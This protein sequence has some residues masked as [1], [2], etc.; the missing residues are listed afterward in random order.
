MDHERATGEPT[1]AT[2]IV[3]HQAVLA[4]FDGGSDE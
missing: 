4:L 2:A 3:S 1:F